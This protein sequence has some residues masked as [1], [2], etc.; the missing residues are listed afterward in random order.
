MLIPAT[1]DLGSGRS[2]TTTLA[3][4]GDIA[5]RA[6]IDCWLQD[7]L[8]S[9]GQVMAFID[10]KTEILDQDMCARCGACVAVCPPGFLALDDQGRPVPVATDAM[11]CGS[12]SLC[13]QVCP[14][15]DTGT[16]VSEERIFA[17]TRTAVRALD[18]HISAAASCC[19]RRM[20]RFVANAAAGGAG[21]TLM[22]T[23]L[24]TGTA[25]GVIVIGRDADRPW[26]PAAMI[27]DDESEVIRCAQ[28]SYCLTPNLQLLRDS[29]LFA[30]CADRPA[31]RGASRAQNAEHPA[32]TPNVAAKVVLT[33]EIACASSTT[34]AGTEHL[35]TD[36]LGIPLVEVA[37]MR[38][39]DGEY[40]GRVCGHHARRTAQVAALFSQSWMNSDASR[41]TVVSLARTGGQVSPTSPSPM[42]IPISM[43][44][45]VDGSHP[46]RQSIVLTRTAGRRGDRASRP[47]GVGFATVKDRPFIAESNLGLQ[48]K[49][50]RYASFADSPPR[51]VP[52]APVEYRELRPGVDRR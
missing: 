38:Y 49:R 51:R 17:R 10:L 29:R 40:P 36:K 18:R 28:T 44:A 12:C 24:R 27:T 26:V 45:V 15:K 25:D 4:A 6:P 3:N 13:Q 20:S 22:L 1:Q 32:D 33:I 48:R 46:R 30:H 16:P 19:P 39:R 21:T 52:T 11:D 23:G 41:P 37:Q 9:P 43:R 5:R 7:L 31:L 47:F 35:I 8:I 50:F 14:G 2:Q 42:A 34:R